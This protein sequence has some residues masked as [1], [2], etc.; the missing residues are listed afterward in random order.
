MKIYP[1]D[2]CVTAAEV[3]M[4]RGEPGAVLGVQSH[5]LFPFLCLAGTDRSGAVKSVMPACPTIQNAPRDPKREKGR[6]SPF[7]RSDA[8]ANAIRA[9]AL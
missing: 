5:F 4:S 8:E 2:D 6:R 3:A 7:D 9:A 1:F